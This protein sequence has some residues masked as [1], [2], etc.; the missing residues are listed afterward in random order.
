MNNGQRVSNWRRRTKLNLIEEA[1]GCCQ[2]CGYNKHPGALEFHHIDPSTKNFHLSRKGTTLAYE[3]LRIEASKCLL[4]CANC[5]REVE[6]KVTSINNLKS[7]IDLTKAPL[8][9]RVI[10]QYFYCVDCSKRCSD[11]ASR[12]VQ[13]QSKTR[14]KIN[15]PLIEDLEKMVAQ[16]SY[17]SVGRELGVSDNAVRKHIKSILGGENGSRT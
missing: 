1:G 15:W 3:K 10:K 9:Q 5:H 11:H 8:Q 14:H 2:V 17:L 16:T 4:L 13:C 7:L 12:C 6:G